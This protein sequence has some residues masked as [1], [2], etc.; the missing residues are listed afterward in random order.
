MSPGAGP[1]GAARYLKAVSHVRAPGP[2]PALEDRKRSAGWH[3][4]TEQPVSSRN[5]DRLTPSLA[6]SLHARNEALGA[7]LR[8]FQN[9]GKVMARRSAGTTTRKASST[10]PVVCGQCCELADQEAVMQAL[11]LGTTYVHGCG[12]VMVSVRADGG[13]RVRA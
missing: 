4:G 3:G 11:R 2:A 12:R 6:G 9:G 1:A 5:P 8:R 10:Y 13:L 7:T